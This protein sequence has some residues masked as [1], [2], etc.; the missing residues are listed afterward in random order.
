MLE[1][2]SN[3]LKIQG[4]NYIQPS[5]LYSTKLLIE[6]VREYT[7]IFWHERLKPCTHNTSSLR[8]LI[9][10][11]LYKKRSQEK[12]RHGLLKNKVFNAWGR[13]VE[14]RRQRMKAE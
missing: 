10:D 5:V 7:D 11:E 1:Q 2:K 6:G 9:K 13:G 3:I 12:E 8:K 14:K 4:N